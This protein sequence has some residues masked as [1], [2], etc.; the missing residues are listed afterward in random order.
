MFVDAADYTY[1]GRNGQSRRSDD[2]DDSATLVDGNGDGVTWHRRMARVRNAVA[3]VADCGSHDYRPAP[4]KVFRCYLGFGTSTGAA[5]FGGALIFAISLVRLVRFAA[6]SVRPAAT[7][8]Y[9]YEAVQSSM[10]RFARRLQAGE[11]AGLVCSARAVAWPPVRKSRLPW[12]RRPTSRPTRVRAAST[13]STATEAA[14][15]FYQLRRPRRRAPRGEASAGRRRPRHRPRA[16]ALDR[17]RPR[18]QAS[19]ADRH[20][21]QE[22]AHRQA[23]REQEARRL[24]DR[25]TSGKRSLP[26]SS[27]KPLRGRG[28]RA[29]DRRQRQARHDL[30]HVRPLGPDRRLAVVLVGRRAGARSST[31]STS[32]RA[33]SRRAS[34]P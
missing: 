34:R 6:I 9:A 25:R 28:P 8:N 3:E 21:G 32:C 2:F 1:G 27:S 12:H 18:R 30:R 15:L 17:R 26:R 16:A 31:S 19:R 23:G 13:L 29:G 4:A 14:P 10:Q 24:G 7:S 22:S 5:Q 11:L 33:A 20:A